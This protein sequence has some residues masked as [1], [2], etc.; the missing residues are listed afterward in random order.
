MM[1]LLAFNA[2]GRMKKRLVIGISGATGS[3]YAIRMLEALKDT[4]IETHLVISGAAE[5]TIQLETDYQIDYVESLANFVYDIDNVG[6][7]IASGSF[8]SM[9]MVVI[10]CSIKTLSGV[11]NSFNENLLIRAAD[12]VLKERRTLVLMVRETPFHKGHLRLMAQ[13]ADMGAVIIPPSPSFY[14]KPK[15]IDDILNQTVGRI[16]D[17]FGI[18]LGLFKRWSGEDGE[19]AMEILKEGR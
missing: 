1:G 6:A 2:E 8:E 14:T 10:P 13:A 15:T 18:R 9:G 19:R 4:D 3:I 16:L 17:F 12:V 7:A 5:T 11:A